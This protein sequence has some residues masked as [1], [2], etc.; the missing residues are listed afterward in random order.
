MP[1]QNE[2]EPKRP[3]MVRPINAV[4]NTIENHPD[5][6]RR[7]CLF[8][9][10]A[11]LGGLSYVVLKPLISNFLPETENENSTQIQELGFQEVT[12][13][14]LLPIDE[15][16]LVINAS[17][18]PLKIEKTSD[19]S[20]QQVR[21]TFESK[22]LDNLF[23]TLIFADSG[24]SYTF[25]ELVLFATSKDRLQAMGELQ[26]SIWW[27][28]IPPT[29]IDFFTKSIKE[30]QTH[31]QEL[32]TDI[33]AAIYATFKSLA[34]DPLARQNDFKYEVPKEYVLD[35]KDLLENNTIPKLLEFQAL[36]NSEFSE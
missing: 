8:L 24:A 34:T 16:N 11:L 28:Y 6:T 14:D 33:N 23:L 26:E 22:D 19:S 1:N 30:Q 25:K 17:S 13:V 35:Y 4:S 36:I 29:R 5:L 27:Y 32:E 18:L 7:G 20:W 3:L 2:V 31:L 15:H 21:E 9:G 12:E 10:S